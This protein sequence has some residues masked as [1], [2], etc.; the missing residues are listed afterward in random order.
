[1]IWSPKRDTQSPVT[2]TERWQ[3]VLSAG[4]VMLHPF[5][6]AELDAVLLDRDAV[7]PAERG[8]F[9]QQVPVPRAPAAAGAPAPGAIASL[10]RLGFVRPDWPSQPGSPDE[11]TGWSADPAGGPDGRRPV[12]LTGDLAII[13]R[14]RA[15]P[16]W[17]A[18]VSISPE[19][20]RPQPGAAR[21]RLIAR[22]YASFQPPVRLIER[23]PRADGTLPPAAL[24][25]DD[26]ALLTLTGLCGADASR[27]PGGM[28]PAGPQTR[29]PLGQAPT[30]ELAG[31]FRSLAQLRVVL[32][33]GQRVLLRSL[34]VASSG[35][36]NWLLTGEQWEQATEISAGDL[37]DRVSSLLAGPGHAPAPWAAAEAGDELRRDW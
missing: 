14:I 34:L 24:L 28:Q 29:G 4:Q 16:V 33:D 20:G 3:Q 10:E 13:T 36:R 17:L 31:E 9:L 23:L 11:L 8:A 25:R 30:A 12:T 22:M 19:P 5:S 6:Q 27:R 15:Q 26:R 7:P 18:E 21:W 32:A 37:T 1:M 35:T 2:V